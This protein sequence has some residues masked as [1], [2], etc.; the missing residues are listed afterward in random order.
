MQVEELGKLKGKNPP[1]PV[2][3]PAT[4]RL[5]TQCLNRL[6]YRVP[7]SVVLHGQSMACPEDILENN[8]FHT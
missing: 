8:K 5:E 1:H 4:I 6:R 2:L 7:L 3:E